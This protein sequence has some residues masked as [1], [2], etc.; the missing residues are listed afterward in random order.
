MVT[1]KY[2]KGL[3]GWT[4]FVMTSGSAASNSPGFPIGLAVLGCV[5]V[6]VSSPKV[7]GSCMLH[8]CVGATSDI[9]RGNRQKVVS[10][11]E[12]FIVPP[13]CGRITLS[14]HMEAIVVSPECFLAQHPLCEC[15]EACPDNCALLSFSPPILTYTHTSRIHPIHT[16][17]TC[18]HL[19]ASLCS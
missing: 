9:R 18:V 17:R 19:H 6:V 5:H 1:L 16:P 11:T 15:N 3:P 2:Q 8:A 10:T 13:Q 12:C 7:A 4:V 14:Y